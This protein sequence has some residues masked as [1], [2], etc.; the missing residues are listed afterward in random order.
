MTLKDI[1]KLYVNLSHDKVLT[2]KRSFIE[3]TT[4]YIYIRYRHYGSS[5]I[6]HNFKNF[7]W[8]MKTI[9]KDYTLKDLTTI[10]I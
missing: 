3:I 2:D 4:N 9:F 7:T 5:A 8:L 10:N 6:K 1:K